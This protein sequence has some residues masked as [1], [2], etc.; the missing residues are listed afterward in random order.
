MSPTPHVVVCSDAAAVFGEA[1]RRFVDAARQ[2]MAA[3]GRFFAALSGGST[4]KGLYELL[5]T[6][7]W[8]R[9]VDWGKV[10]V[11][12]GDERFVPPVSAQ[13]NFGMANAALLSKVDILPSNIFRVPTEAG[14]AE[15]AAAVYEQTLRRALAAAPAATP[16][17]D[18]VLLGLG[19]NGHT[20]SLFPHTQVL[21]E[22]GRLV[23]AVYVEEVKAFRITMTARLLNRARGLMFLATGGEKASVLN[24]VL[25]GEFDPERLPAQLVRPDSGDVTWIVDQAAAAQLPP[26]A[27][28][29]EKG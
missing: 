9:Q 1:A 25:F 4:P 7:E 5:A 17:L 2:T 10:L 3:R 16:A 13:S 15:E 23:A 6:P 27:V 28:E 18:L 11:F 26:S 19:T 14:S 22:T 21:R 12:W 20:A 29:G 24:E 8:S